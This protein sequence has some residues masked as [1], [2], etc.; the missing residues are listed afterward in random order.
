MKLAIVCT[1]LLTV[2]E[3]PRDAGFLLEGKPGLS[4]GMTIKIGSG[5]LAVV[6]LAR[7]WSAGYAFLFCWCLQGMLMSVGDWSGQGPTV[8]GVLSILIRLGLLAWLAH[9]RI[10]R[11]EESP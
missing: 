7:H 3:L 5:I 9:H 10:A 4:L 1:A 6:G 11:K 2:C 8:A